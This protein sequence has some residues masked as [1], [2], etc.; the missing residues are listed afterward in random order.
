MLVKRW[1]ISCYNTK[2]INSIDLVV[3][4]IRISI[5]VF[6]YHIII[7]RNSVQLK[8]KAFNRGRSAMQWVNN[9]NS[10]SE[11]LNCSMHDHNTFRISATNHFDYMVNH[12]WWCCLINF[13]AVWSISVH[14]FRNELKNF[15]AWSLEL[16]VFKQII[17]NT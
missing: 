14:A 2:K 7:I 10:T 8:L 3:F 11:K 5:W 17:S 12:H 9:N 15:V 16:W 4:S 1:C 6:C 13:L